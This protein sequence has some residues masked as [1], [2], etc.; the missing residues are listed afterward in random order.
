MTNLFPVEILLYSSEHRLQIKHVVMATD[1]MNLLKIQINKFYQRI[2]MVSRSREWLKMDVVPST[3]SPGACCIQRQLGF[4]P[5]Q[6]FSQ[7]SIPTMAQ[8]KG[9]N[10][11]FISLMMLIVL[12]QEPT[13]ATMHSID[14]I[15]K[16]QLFIVW[17]KRFAVS[18]PT[19]AICA[20]NS[21]VGDSGELND[22]WKSTWYP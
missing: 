7:I 3:F 15:I 2:A 21:F 17:L 8:L 18:R 6:L 1:I 5:R 22:S 14:Q 4:F 19:L 12:I 9:Q 13:A 11:F 16:I 20:Q 10:Q